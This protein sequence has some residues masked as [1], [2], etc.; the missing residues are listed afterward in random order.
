MDDDEVKITQEIPKF[1]TKINL[2]SHNDKKVLVLVLFVA[3]QALKCIVDVA[4]ES[5]S[6]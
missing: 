6:E 1:Y 5:A 4:E 3:F 2:R